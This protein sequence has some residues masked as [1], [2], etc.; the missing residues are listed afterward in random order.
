M[1]FTSTPDRHAGTPRRLWR[2]SHFENRV[3]TLA[4]LMCVLGLTLATDATGQSDAVQWRI[5]DGGNGHWYAHDLVEYPAGTALC[6]IDWLVDYA[7]GFGSHPV[8]ITS[9]EEE[10]FVLE[11][12][13]YFNGVYST[14]NIGCR[15]ESASSPWYWVTGEPFEYSN[16]IGGVSDGQVVHLY[17]EQ[18]IFGPGWRRGAEC[19]VAEDVTIGEGISTILEWS[20]DCNGDGIVDYGQILDGAFSDDDGNGVPDC[21]DAGEACDQD[22]VQWR[23][24]DGGNGHWYRFVDRSP[25]P[26]GIDFA[27]L[28]GEVAALG[29]HLVSITSDLEWTFLKSM[30]PPAGGNFPGFWTGLR[31]SECD[32]W[33]WTSGEEVGFSAWG[34]SACGAGPYPNDCYGDNLGMFANDRFIDCG[35]NWDDFPQGLIERAEHIVEWSADCNGDGIVDYGQILDGTFADLNSNGVPDHCEDEATATIDAP[36]LALGT[37]FAAAITED[38]RVVVW[39]D[40]THGVLNVPDGI[41]DPV[42]IA[43]WERHVLVLQAD[44]RVVCWGDNT[45]GQANVPKG[46]APAVSIAG[47][48]RGS[49]ALH[50][51]GSV[52]G[53][54]DDYWCGA[55]TTTLDMPDGVDIRE[56][57][58]GNAHWLY[59][60]SNGFVAGRGCNFNGQW[61]VPNAAQPPLDFEANESWSCVLSPAGTIHVFGWGGYG[62]PNAPTGSDHVDIACGHYFG[63]ALAADGS[64]RHWGSN[65]QGQGNVPGGLEAVRSLNAGATYAAAI[66][67]DGTLTMWGDNSSGQCDWPTGER[68]RLVDTDC[69]ADGV[70][71]WRE[72]LEGTG[73][74][75]DGDGRL[76]EC[77][78]PDE[79]VCP[80][81][82]SGD[83][84][85]DPID[86]GL[87]LSLWGTDGQNNPQADIDG[88]G[89]IDSI[90]LGMVLSGWGFCPEG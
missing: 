87:L 13:P 48:S 29:G 7:A 35:W 36:K 38:G 17:D 12:M 28:D 85:V 58:G 47:L 8:T 73:V 70:A 33:R 66:H 37:G 46:L 49:L 1:Q 43:A 90:D 52:S 88:N 42:E 22:A 69:D 79:P 65:Q 32:V 89:V 59:R 68:I 34:T 77:D 64:I 15:R 4:P 3:C 26:G 14:A 78:E 18:S 63:L 75:A 2:A 31:S 76:D 72:I 10:S 21:C 39:G 41:V 71:D 53:W 67:E 55:G 44:G 27:E 6:G 23:I 45:Y 20:A 56:I 81:D 80:A 11:V 57:S 61:N 16:F 60:M 82:L 86:L 54:G 40:N 9:A 19:F 30:I 74:D 51:D 84:I 25:V 83:G 5:E 62:I 24:E 50:A